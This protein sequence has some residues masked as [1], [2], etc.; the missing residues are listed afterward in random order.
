MNKCCQYTYKKVLEELVFF[1]RINKPE[2]VERLLRAL[3]HAVSM[4]ND[5]GEF[6]E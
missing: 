4:L 3:E 5:I 6:D 1:I 2:S